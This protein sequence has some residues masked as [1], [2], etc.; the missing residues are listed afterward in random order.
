MPYQFA[1]QHKQGQQAELE[2]DQ[3]FQRWYTITPA[4][5]AQ[6]RN[7]IDRVF[8]YRGKQHFVEYKCDA[9]SETTGNFFLETISVERNSVVVKEGWAY[10]T[11]AGWVVLY[12]P[13]KRR[14]IILD[15]S[16]L[17]GRMRSWESCFPKRVI[18]NRTWNTHG[19]LV[20][21]DILTTTDICTG[22]NFIL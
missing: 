9:K 21:E 19:I 22:A 12:Q 4:T 5:P 10:T 1:T 14:V 8:E 18:P 20:P 16:R 7:G 15:A 13:K 17:K 3:Y 11:K 6:Q 2:L